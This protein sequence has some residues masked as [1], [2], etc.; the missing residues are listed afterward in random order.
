VEIL[1]IKMLVRFR[2]MNW[3]KRR[4]INVMLLPIACI[5]PSNLSSVY[6]VL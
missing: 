3:N 1:Y 2:Q 6:G 4:E 5:E